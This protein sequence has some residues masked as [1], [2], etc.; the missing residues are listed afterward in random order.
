MKS[1]DGEASV[2]IDQRGTE[3]RI[4]LRLA[5]DAAGPSGANDEPIP[6]RRGEVRFHYQ[7]LQ[8]GNGGEN[9]FLYVIPLGANGA[10]V[11]GRTTFKV[12]AAHVGDGQWHTQKVEFATVVA[13][14]HAS[15]LLHLPGGRHPGR[16]ADG[17]GGG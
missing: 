17:S 5:A 11:P 14:R 9:L 2:G 15:R 16:G 10:E 7:A 6:I 13:Q 3:G 8:S 1:A 4:A 12:P